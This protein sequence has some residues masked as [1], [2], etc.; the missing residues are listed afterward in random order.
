LFIWG[1]GSEGQLGMGDEKTES[2]EPT[3]VMFDEKVTCVSC[4]YY[5]TAVITGK[6]PG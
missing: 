1:G 5:H 4:G 6:M 3:E 2:P